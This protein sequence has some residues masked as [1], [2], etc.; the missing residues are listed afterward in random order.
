MKD[1]TKPWLYKEVIEVCFHIINNNNQF[2][3]HKPWPPTKETGRGM[4][5]FK[6][7]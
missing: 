7:D 4:F 1:S 6:R 2:W 5:S 3:L